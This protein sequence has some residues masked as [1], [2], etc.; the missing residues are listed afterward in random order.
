MLKKLVPFILWLVVI[1]VA[2]PLFQSNEKGPHLP[3]SWL[4]E[5]AR[6]ESHPDHNSNLFSFKFLKKFNGA[7]TS[8]RIL[9]AGKTPGGRR[10][11]TSMGRSYCDDRPLFLLHHAFLFYDAT[12]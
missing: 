10:A 8:N 9:A 1:A 4:E 7:A 2:L 3:F 5:G 6:L 12:S 11:E